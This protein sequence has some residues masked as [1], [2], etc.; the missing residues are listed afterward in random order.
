MQ[1]IIPFSGFTP[2]TIQFLRE[3]KVNNFRE[4]FEDHRE[5]YDIELIQPFKALVATLSPVMYNID[6]LFEMRPHKVLSRIYRDIRFSKN[7]EPY[8]TC[9]WMSF[10]RSKTQWQNFPG[11][12]MELNT[13]RVF[14]G[15]G[16]YQPQRKIIDTFREHVEMEPDSFEKMVQQ[17]VD[18]NG[19]SLEGE[20]YKRPLK[21]TLS[22]DLQPWMQR[23][24]VY[25]M[26]EIAINNPII[27][28][29]KLAKQLAHDFTV[30]AQL[31]QFMVEATEEAMS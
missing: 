9:L 14:Y 15:M 6:A 16:M 10:Q 12:F 1:R 24:S 23:K 4:W 17:S 8:K 31:Y 27:Y 2:Q 20:K 13:E 11:F 22:D 26:K 7:K 3:L 25:V 28:S 29:D 30:L 21:N 5:V 19:F 18:K